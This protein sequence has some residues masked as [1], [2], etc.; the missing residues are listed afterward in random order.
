MDTQRVT[1][2]TGGGKGI[3]RAI[4]LRMANKTNIVIVGR[5]EEE[6]LATKKEIENT[7]G[8]VEYVAGDVADPK[9]AAKTMVRTQEKGW[10]VANL[11]CN[12]GIGKG[13]PT[14][15]LD[16][17][18][19]HEIMEVNLDG[20]FYF[21]QACLPLML[22]QKYGVICIMGS[23]A[24]IKGYKNNAAYV[25]S[26]HA[27][28]GLARTLAVEYGKYG[29]VTVPLC[30]G[31]VMTEMTERSIHGLMKR[32]NISFEEAEKI[33]AEVN[34]QHRIISQEEIAEMVA[35]VCE[36]K[37]PSLSGNPLILSGGE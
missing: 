15:T 19:W 1:I 32:K 11:V 18:L 16:S 35:F 7:G 37:V 2:I 20:S 12:A 31:F 30:P 21:I 13:G 27:L 4:A 17:S 3:G 9:T 26:K 23:M 28:L 14:A 10:V 33:I 29:I 34:P 22:E 25:A 8:N 24:S 6:L 36:N 5:N